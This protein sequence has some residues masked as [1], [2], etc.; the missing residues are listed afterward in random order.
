MDYAR[1]RLLQL[2]QE[3]QEVH[4]TVAN[5]FSAIEQ[6]LTDRQFL[7]TYVAG[8]YLNDAQNEF[9]RSWLEG[10]G[11]WLALHGS[12]GGKAARLPGGGRKMEKG[13]HHETLGALFI[14]PPAAVQVPRRRRGSL[15]PAH[16]RPP[17]LLRGHG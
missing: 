17:R 4:A 9:V 3:R 2:L 10:G 6:W 11:R 8:P 14:H 12:S 5:D 7:I 13:S 16:P 1:L 15:A